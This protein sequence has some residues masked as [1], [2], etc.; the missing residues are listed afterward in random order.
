MVKIFVVAAMEVAERQGFTEAAWIDVFFS[1][2]SSPSYIGLGE[3]PIAS[4]TFLM[5]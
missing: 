1:L 5:T 4:W 2:G 3:S